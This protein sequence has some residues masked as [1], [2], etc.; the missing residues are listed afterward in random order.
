MKTNPTTNKNVFGPSKKCP[1]CYEY[2]PMHAK[3]CPACKTRVREMD[4]SG[5]ARRATDW[6]AYGLAFFAILIFAF[7][8][9]W[10]FFSEID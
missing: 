7:Y 3:I 9:W 8:I 2:M 1:E 10:A 5:M 4:D 6:K